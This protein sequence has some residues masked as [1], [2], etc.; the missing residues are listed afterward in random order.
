[1]T[2]STTPQINHAA[3]PTVFASSGHKPSPPASYNWVYTI[4]ILLALIVFGV[5]LYLAI[6]GQSWAILAAGCAGLLGVLVTWPIALAITMTREEERQREAELTTTITER[7][8]GISLL[9]NLMS[10]QQLLSDRAKSV[11]FRDKDREALRR[12]IQ[13]D[14]GRN[15]FEA[16][17]A[18]VDDMERAFGLKTEADRCRREIEE[19]RLEFV[20]RQIEEAA[21]HIDV[22]CRL[23][24]WTEASREAERV[25]AIYPGNEQAIRLPQEIESRR[26]QFKKDLLDSW[27]DATARN[28]VD[29]AIEILK[30][31]DLYLSRTEA[32]TMKDKVRNV[33]A[34]KLKS[35][36]TQFNQA[37]QDKNHKEQLRLAEI[38][39]RDFPNSGIAREL[40]DQLSSLRKTAAEPVG[41]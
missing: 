28:D 17:E 29:G 26:Q 16:A 11:A 39:I 41:A 24:R 13:E 33:F 32:E 7:L 15:D 21:G 23:E 31:L 35:L 4:A 9:L 5:G 19:F 22:H 37:R 27:T 30:K 1:M 36:G 34:D 12:A 2:G 6:T 3:T 25:I 38:I 14:L 18:L 8:Q 40:R 20:R 10:E